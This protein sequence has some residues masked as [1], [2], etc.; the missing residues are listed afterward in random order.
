MFL[1][2]VLYCL[3][4]HIFHLSSSGKGWQ[5][6]DLQVVSALASHQ[7]HKVAFWCRS[8]DSWFLEMDEQT[9]SE[10]ACQPLCQLSCER[11]STCRSLWSWWER[12]DRTPPA[13]P[14]R[15]WV[16]GD[17][18]G[19]AFQCWISQTLS[20]M[21]RPNQGIDLFG[22][23]CKQFPAQFRRG[24]NFPKLWPPQGGT[25]RSPEAW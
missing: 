17:R 2:C 10:A 11:L 16:C 14:W 19:S 5:P 8:E 4:F 6:I 9:S 20:Q 7:G 25:C 3:R 22:H 21:H 15:R 18:P 23:G 1:F 12:T 13:Y 24:R